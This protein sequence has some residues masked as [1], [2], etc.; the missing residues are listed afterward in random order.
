MSTYRNKLLDLVDVRGIE[1][2]D[3]REFHVSAQA[4]EHYNFDETLFAVTGN[5]VLADFQAARDFAQAMNRKRDLVR[6][7]DRAVRAGDVNAMGLIDEIMHHLVSV[8]LEQTGP[9]LFSEALSHLKEQHG[10]TVVEELLQRFVSDFP[11]RS[12][13]VGEKT[14][15]Q[16]LD[17]EVDG[18]SAREVAAEE[19]LMLYLENENP[20]FDPFEELFDDS[21][22]EEETRYEEVIEEFQRFFSS[23]PAFGPEGL[24]L[25]ELLRAPM[26][27]HPDSLEAQLAYMRERWGGFLGPY[28]MRLLRGMDLIREEHKARFAG[29]GPQLPYEFDAGA[30]EEVERFSP[31]QDWMPNVV[32]LA[33]STLV[34]LDQLSRSYG[35]EI[36]RLDQV[37]DEELDRIAARG[38]NSLWLIGIWRRSLASKQIKR[39]CGN[40]EAEASAYSLLEY[41]ISED[42]GGWPALENLRR[43]CL[44]RGLLLAS[45]MVPNHTAIDSTWVYD[46]PDRFVQLDHSPFP[47]YTFNGV[48]L[49]QRP[50]IGIYLEDHYYDRSDAAVVFK[51]VDFA[52]GDV[53]YIYHGNDGT[54][55]PW[56]DTAQV[57][58][59]NPEAR[60]AVIQAIL[61]VARNFRVIRFDAAMI[62]AKR[63][64]QRLW[65]PEPG[66]GGDIA[67]RAEHGLTA[68]DFNRAMPAEFW[69]EVVDRCAQEAPN[70]LLLAEAFWMMEGYFVRT[71]GM[72][73]VYNSAFMNMLKDE[74]NAKYRQTIKNT[75][76]FDKEILKRFV[77]FMNNPDEETA[78]SQFG[79]GD[80]Y[81]GIATLMVTMPGLPMFGH[82]QIEGYAEKYGMEYSRAYWDESPDDELVRRHEREIFPLLRRRWAFSG[83]EH[84]LL[85]DLYAADGRV[86]EDVYVYTNRAGEERTLVIF[87]NA[88]ERAFG[89]IHESAGYVEKMPD[90]SKDFRRGS[91]AGAFGLSD[92]HRRFCLLYEQRRGV[93]YIRNS[94][95]LHEQ[96]MYVAIDGFEN[97]VF[98]DIH[99]VADNEYGHYARLADS[100]RGDGVRDIGRA[101]AETALAPLHQSFSGVANSRV[102]G[103]LAVELAGKTS[104]EPI[105]EAALAEHYRAFAAVAAQYVGTAEAGGH[106]DAGAVGG[107]DAAAA[108]FTRAMRA[109]RSVRELRTVSPAKAKKRYG[110]TAGLLLDGLTESPTGLGTAFAL[111]L[112]RPL[113]RVLPDA[114]LAATVEEWMLLDRLEPVLPF[115]GSETEY[116]QEWKRRTLIVIAHG[117][118]YKGDGTAGVATPASVMETI[119]SDVDAASYLGVNRHEEV[120]W[121]NKE[122]FDILAFWLFTGAVLEVLED[123]AAAD[124]KVMPDAKVARRVLE[125]SEYY[126][127]WSSAAADSG[128]K[129][130]ALLKNL[131]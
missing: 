69:R 61:H 38:F 19:L 97:Q 8:Y 41:E 64:Y 25:F 43:R 91:L 73:R 78:V 15:R 99:E 31:D 47:G 89:W 52:N 93:W 86:N 128:Y 54:S 6:H 121:F 113:A 29:P 110:A 68:E 39:M 75:I 16:F 51:R 116:R 95:E 129:V 21:G 96:G 57:D 55:M 81:F 3:T 105:D 36:R 65:Y 82:G 12:V 126:D 92:D 60:E 76:E 58:F 109:L 35:T 11:P 18:Q 90:G 104:E 70:T 10:E 33:K 101:L 119:F 112:C 80:K 125:L 98:L 46:N 67:S 100:L 94:H 37:P 71:L 108:D 13:R 50:G 2:G 17:G 130:E 123:S 23:Q 20:A 42:L 40:P 59:L 117:G 44:R 79:K 114:R 63:H 72:H 103:D 28:L 27:A 53:R 56:N 106:A 14:P 107:P 83:V 32:L 74:E 1:T 9:G 62:L 77:N 66:S 30:E 120:V 87:N 84:F 4:R 115:G 88:Y 131:T 111:A 7:P 122:R 102:L 85:F 5:A 118:W 22:L 45:D 34:W 49:S 124:G 24:S 48:N 127:A 26:R